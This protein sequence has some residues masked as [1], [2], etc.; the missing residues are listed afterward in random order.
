MCL[1]GVGENGHAYV[2]DG[3]DANGR[4]SVNWGWGGYYDGF[5]YM[6]SMI[7]DGTDYSV[8]TITIGI[9]PEAIKY[10]YNDE[11]VVLTTT[12]MKQTNPNKFDIHDDRCN[13]TL[14][15]LYESQLKGAYDIDENFAVY[16]NGQFL[17]YFYSEEQQNTFK[18]EPY[19]EYNKTTLY[20]KDYIM[21]LLKDHGVYKLVPVSRQHGTEVWKENIGSD[22]K[23]LTLINPDGKSIKVFVGE[24]NSEL[25]EA[26]KAEV[27]N[28][29]SNLENAVTEK[30]NTLNTYES[31]FDAIKTGVEKGKQMIEDMNTMLQSVQ[32]LYDDYKFTTLSDQKTTI[33][34]QKYKY[35]SDVSDCESELNSLDN[36]IFFSSNYTDLKAEL[37]S[38]QKNIKGQLALTEFMTKQEYKDAI[39]YDANSF[40][41]QIQNADVKGVTDQLDGL[42]NDLDDLN[43]QQLYDEVKAFAYQV[44]LDAHGGGMKGDVNGDGQVDGKDVTEVANFIL[45]KPSDQFKDYVADMNLDKKVDAADLVILIDMSS[46]K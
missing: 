34:N 27:T 20:I 26:E 37:R 38:L 23:Y 8:Y 3:Y 24:P 31:T 43:I 14:D 4:L 41:G 1:G 39:G 36:S 16:Q 17:T 7:A 2:V 42:K 29:Y 30:L 9:S 35:N 40:S 46:K 45:G 44:N 22:E 28:I 15:I 13:L 11:D 18:M 25:T 5:Y 6:N 21:Q 12:R 19:E 32:Q 33:Y 10:E